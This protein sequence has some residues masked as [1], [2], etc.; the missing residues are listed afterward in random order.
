[1]SKYFFSFSVQQ[2]E[3]VHFKLDTNE[4][5][6]R[7][8]KVHGDKYSYSKTKYVNSRTKVVVICQ[9]HGEFS[10]KPTAHYGQGHGCRKCKNKA[11]EI[12]FEEFVKRSRK[13][14][15][16]KFTYPDQDFNGI[17]SH[18]K[19]ICPTHGEFLQKASSHSRGIGCSRCAGRG[20]GMSYSNND[21]ISAARKIHGEKYD[22]SLTKY[23][24]SK[25][26]VKIICKEHGEFEQ[27]ANNHLTGQGC[28]ECGYIL[29]SKKGRKKWQEIYP[30][31]IEVHQDKYTYDAS[32]YV[33]ASS[34]I[35]VYCKIHDH[36]FKMSPVTLIGGQGCYHCGIDKIKT[37]LTKDWE[38]TFDLIKQTHG[39][40]YKYNVKSFKG[41]KEQMEIICAKH[42]AFMQE[43][44]I[45]IV[46]HGCPKCGVISGHNLQRGTLEKFIKRAKKMHGDLYDYSKAK[47]IDVATDVEIIC[48]EH[49]SFFMSPN[50]HTHSA[51]SRG[52]PKC[53]TSSGERLITVFLEKHEVKYETQKK[54]D[55]LFSFRGKTNRNKLKCDFYLP[56][57]NTVIEY[58]GKQHYMP[59]D[60]FGGKKSLEATRKNDRIKQQ[61]CIE[62]HI[63]Y[64]VIRYDEDVETR[65]DAIIK[66]Y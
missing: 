7:S 27:K 38:S 18:I 51:Q 23:I 32:S 64:E 15:G 37:F 24:N 40:R 16:D 60:L 12:S 21:F 20:R 4:F 34:K 59:I 56:T 61:Y 6:K 10:V 13:F 17:T 47:Y 46:K 9:E 30:E 57:I 52:C 55:D 53:Y 33:K 58:N 28:R 54:F 66:K 41:R 45:H 39:D 50:S 2:K 36:K 35:D 8:K 3:K 49:G 11:S 42:G 31:L 14:H 29:V 48:K 19:I 25:T 65:M 62:N 43:P 22:Y 1:M 5:I 44:S 26:K 63:N